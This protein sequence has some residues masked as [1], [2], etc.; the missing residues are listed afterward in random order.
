MNFT[1]ASGS[2]PR[3]GSKLSGSLPYAPLTRD[4]IELSALTSLEAAIDDPVCAKP[5]GAPAGVRLKPPAGTEQTTSM[6]QFIRPAD[7]S[8]TPIICVPRPLEFFINH[9][10]SSPMDAGSRNESRKVLEA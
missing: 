5:S 2:C 1:A 3:L 7:A 6:T 10:P 8:A 4:W 9:P